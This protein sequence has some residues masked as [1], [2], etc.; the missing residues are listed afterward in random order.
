MCPNIKNTVRNILGATEHRFMRNGVDYSNYL[1]RLDDILS[2]DV[3]NITDRSQIINPY[4]Y[5]DVSLYKNTSGGQSLYN[6]HLKAL[7]NIQS[8]QE[9]SYKEWYDSEEQQSIRQRDAGLNPNLTELSPSQSSDAQF[10]TDSPL[11][12]IPTTGDQI[13]KVASLVSAAASIAALPATFAATSA[14]ASLATSQAALVGAQK[15]GQQ[16]NNIKSFEGLIYA[17]A[18]GQF[19]DAV[20]GAAASGSQFVPDDFFNNLR[21]DDTLFSAYAPEDTP[22]YRAAYGRAINQVQKIKGEGFKLGTDSATN[23][24][25]FAEA[26]SNPYYDKDVLLQIASLEPVMQAFEDLRLLQLDYDTTLLRLSDP[27]LDAAAKNAKYKYESDYFNGFNGDEVAA[28]EFATKKADSII[29][30]ATSTIFENYLKIYKK[31]PH[32]AK[33]L[34][35]AYMILNGQHMQ[36]SE[37]LAAFLIAKPSNPLPPSRASEITDDTP[38][39]EWLK[40]NLDEG[41]L[42]D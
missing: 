17:S 29:K 6:E 18:A 2:S 26:L 38:A 24:S 31:D 25:S 10:P 40:K 7:Q 37:F 42:I 3:T 9:A 8:Q 20:A 23:Q 28:A 34:A 41:W 22:Q 27:S 35:A 13:S 36:W 12:G 11:S 21:S 39:D 15:A 14:Q 33:G 16:L 32:S 5:L 4:D 30:S 19:A 1:K